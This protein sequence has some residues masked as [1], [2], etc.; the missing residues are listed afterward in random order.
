MDN[1][2]KTQMWELSEKDCKAAITG[3]LQ[4][5]QVNALN[6]KQNLRRWG[7]G[8]RERQIKKNQIEI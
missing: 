3:I 7:G 4:C 8:S 5:F 6:Q 1:A 2:K